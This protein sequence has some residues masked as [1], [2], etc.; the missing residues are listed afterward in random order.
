MAQIKYLSPE[1]RYEA[2]KKFCSHSLCDRPAAKLR[3]HL[4]ALPSAAPARSARAMYE[5]NNK[6]QQVNIPQVMWQAKNSR[7]R[8]SMGT[9]AY[10]TQTGATCCGMPACRQEPSKATQCIRLLPQTNVVPKGKRPAQQATTQSQQKVPALHRHLSPMRHSAA[11][12]NC[13]IDRTL[14]ACTVSV[15]CTDRPPAGLCTVQSAP[16]QCL[17]QRSM[18]ASCHATAALAPP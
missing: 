9:S 11:Q 2:A 15:P 12:S 13:S 8:S 17:S 4:M 1:S 5:E 18:A 3:S 16:Q 7:P 10:Y 6:P 14:G